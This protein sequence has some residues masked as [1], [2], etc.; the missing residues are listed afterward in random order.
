MT[1]SNFPRAFMYYKPRSQ[2]VSGII[3]ISKNNRILLVKGRKKNKW[4]FPKGHLKSNET[5]HQCAL[6][7]CFEETGISLKDFNCDGYKK[8][9]AG[10]Y[11]IYKDVDEFNTYVQDSHEICDVGWFDVESMMDL[12]TNI[13]VSA[14]LNIHDSII[15]IVL[16]EFDQDC[17]KNFTNQFN[18]CSVNHRINY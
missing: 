2:K 3:L 8:L 6:R 4:S 14:F 5:I 7:E 11:F 13:D 15:N 18:D 1:I 9:T 16:N 12:R 10:E 17:K